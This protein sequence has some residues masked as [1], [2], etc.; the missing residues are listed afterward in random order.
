MI[1]KWTCKETGREDMDWIHVVQDKVQWPCL[2]STVLR[3]LAPDNAE[4]F[5]TT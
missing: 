2:L 3:I 4:I 5:M 1:I